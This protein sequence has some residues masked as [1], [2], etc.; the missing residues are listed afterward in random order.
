MFIPTCP[1]AQSLLRALHYIFH[2]SFDFPY[3]T[4]PKNVL[5][6]KSNCA[7][8]CFSTSNIEG[9]THTQL[10][11]GFHRRKVN[12][13]PRRGPNGWRDCPKNI[14]R[15]TDADGP[16]GS[17]WV[18]LPEWN[19]LLWQEMCTFMLRIA[20]I[21]IWI[22]R[23]GLSCMSSHMLSSQSKPF[24]TLLYFVNKISK[25]LDALRGSSPARQ[26]NCTT[27]CNL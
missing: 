16:F 14:R 3:W 5:I 19:M 12:W 27:P 4:P 10:K 26:I 2:W 23:L 11:I 7:G 22:C 6:A 24:D 21:S 8:R 25:W 9:W 13:L 20:M 17:I 18:A 1:V 15:Q